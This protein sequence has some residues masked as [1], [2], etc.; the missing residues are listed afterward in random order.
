MEYCC[1]LIYAYV[2]TAELQKFV[3]FSYC[4][5]EMRHYYER[6]IIKQSARGYAYKKFIIV[7]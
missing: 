6:Q 5:K 3:C 4:Y 7:S 1:T 2:Q